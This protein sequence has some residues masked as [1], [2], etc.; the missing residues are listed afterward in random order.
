MEDAEPAEEVLRRRRTLDWPATPI[1]SPAV[2]PGL[3]CLMLNP[4][5]L[6]LVSLLF[7]LFLFFLQI[8]SKPSL[9]SRPVF[10]SASA[11]FLAAFFSAFPLLGF[12]RLA[13]VLREGD[14]G[15]RE[16]QD[17]RGDYREKVFQ[18][19]RMRIILRH[20]PA[21]SNGKRRAGAGV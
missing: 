4:E 7:C 18:S 2:E 13:S 19:G 5:L 10:F 20:C 6:R 16:G 15:K 11:F 17:S 21:T 1:K 9:P 8:S 14:S 3:T 12:S